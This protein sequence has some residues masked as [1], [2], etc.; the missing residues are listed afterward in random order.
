MLRQDGTI[1]YFIPEG[2][3]GETDYTAFYP[4]YPQL[5]GAQTDPEPSE[6]DETSTE[7]APTQELV[8]EESADTK[9]E[10]NVSLKILRLLE[11]AVRH[12]SL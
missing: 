6:P 5:P 3:S 2:D 1:G 11:R 9:I 4:V 8:V 10:E 12:A 7:T